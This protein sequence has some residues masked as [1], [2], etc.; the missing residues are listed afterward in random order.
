MILKAE[1]SAHPSLPS[2]SRSV[3]TGD[4]RLLKGRNS[5]QQV[6]QVRTSETSD[7]KYH[8]HQPPLKKYK[9]SVSE[10]L[11]L[12]AERKLPISKSYTQDACCSD[13]ERA[14][15]GLESKIDFDPIALLLSV[16]AE[17]KIVD[18]LKARRDRVLRA[19]EQ[20]CEEYCRVEMKPCPIMLRLEIMQGG[21]VQP[22]V[23]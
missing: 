21:Y 9:S 16:K 5:S 6:G 20:K 10:S 18:G 2:K 12:K 8:V 22:W 15:K 11:S 3:S 19:I 7:T 14:H 13:N 1:P 17:L 4:Q 23:K